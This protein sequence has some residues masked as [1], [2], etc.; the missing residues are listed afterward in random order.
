MLSALCLLLAVGPE[1]VVCLD[2]GHP[3]EVGRGTQGKRITEIAL[4]WS[5]AGKVRPKLEAAGIRVV[6]T[7]RSE[8]E[9]VTNIRRAEIANQASANLM[10]RLHCDASAETGF[11]VFT[12]GKAGTFQGKTGPTQE[13]I[14]RSRAAGEQIHQSLVQQMKGKLRDNGLQP[15]SKT[16]VGSKY[17]ALVGSIYST[18][19][20][21]LV[22]MFTLKNPGGGPTDEEYAITD[23]GQSTMALAL[24]E[25]VKRAVAPRKRNQQR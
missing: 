13:V 4:A 22:E 10:L 2:P 3:S 8:T 19:P 20:V 11:T 16:A 9:Y 24:V 7:K 5:V 25:G 12:P 6:M 14:D 18:V 23:A 21:V 15:D 1:T 17:G